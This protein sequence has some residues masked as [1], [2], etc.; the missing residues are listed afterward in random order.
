MNPEAHELLHELVLSKTGDECRICFRRREF[1]ALL[2]ECCI[3]ERK[4]R[5]HH[6]DEYYTGRCHDE[7]EASRARLAVAVRALEAIAGAAGRIS[8]IHPWACVRGGGLDKDADVTVWKCHR[9][10]VKYERDERPAD[11]L[12]DNEACDTFIARAALA[13]LGKP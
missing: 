10:G 11:D 8:R 1:I 6:C 5:H 2:D 3:C 4:E 9:C 12:C 7:I 13:E